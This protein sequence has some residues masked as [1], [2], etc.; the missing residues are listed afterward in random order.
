MTRSTGLK[1]FFL[2][3]PML[4]GSGVALAQQTGDVL[5]PND[6]VTGGAIAARRPGLVVTSAISRHRERMVSVL[7]NH[8]GAQPQPG[9]GNE[10]HVLLL[11]TI[12]Q[13]IFDIAQNIANAL[14]LA[15]Q[16]STVTTG[17]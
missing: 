3:A 8:G 1:L 13:G 9:T 15:A 14:L 2:F 4:M 16:V 6:R 17:T 10:R 5:Y 11:T 12:L 7:Q